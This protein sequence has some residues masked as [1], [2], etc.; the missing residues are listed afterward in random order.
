VIV[1]DDVKGGSGDKSAEAVGR[2]DG[3]GENIEDVDGTAVKGC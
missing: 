2:E 1:C 3:N